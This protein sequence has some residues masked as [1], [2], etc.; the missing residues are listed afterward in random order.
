MRFEADGLAVGQE[1]RF[2]IFQA[3][4]GA[5]LRVIA[6]FRMRVERQV[7]TVNRQIV[8]DQ[9]PEQFVFFPRPR[10]RR[11]PEQSVM[12]DEQI[13]LGGDGEFDRGEAGIHGGGDA[14][15]RAAIV[16]LQSVR[17]AVVI[18]DSLVRRNWSQW[19]TMAASEVFGIA[20]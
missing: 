7:R 15:D 13:R 4:R 2:E 14:G 12:D 5:K 6:E 8:F 9:Q 16:H 18:A 19:L 11:R 20:R 3:E 10:M 17:R 1:K